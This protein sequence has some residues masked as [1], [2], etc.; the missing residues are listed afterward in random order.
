[1]LT[2]L[3]VTSTLPGSGGSW[4]ASSALAMIGTTT[5]TGTGGASIA[6]S[7]APSTGA[8]ARVSTPS[9]GASAT[10]ASGSASPPTPPAVTR[11]PHA[12]RESVR[13]TR[14]VSTPHHRALIGVALQRTPAPMQ[15]R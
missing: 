1:M 12:A 2:Q 10:T 3:Y 9:A 11:N 13:T 7:A 6:A 8:S 4:S 5:I 15:D 14:A